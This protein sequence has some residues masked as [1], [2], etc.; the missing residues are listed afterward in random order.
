MGALLL[1]WLVQFSVRSLACVQSLTL[2]PTHDELPYAPLAKFSPSWPGEEQGVIVI[3]LTA[4]EFS[5]E[6][7][8]RGIVRRGEPLVAS[9]GPAPADV[10]HRLYFVVRGQ[11]AQLSQF[12]RMLSRSF[13][14]HLAEYRRL[15]IDRGQ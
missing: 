12:R 6:Q 5:T 15:P 8:M 3:R 9:I 11:P 13:P 14:D 7:V 10:D 2:A 4:P 1:I